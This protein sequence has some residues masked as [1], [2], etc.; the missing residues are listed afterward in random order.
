MAPTVSQPPTIAPTPYP[1]RLPTP[2]RPP[3]PTPGGDDDDGDAPVGTIVGVMLV[4]V[5]L[6]ICCGVNKSKIIENNFVNPRQAS[7]DFREVILE[8]QR[9]VVSVPAFACCGCIKNERPRLLALFFTTRI[10]AQWL[11]VHA[12][13]Q[14]ALGWLS[15]FC[16]IISFF[17][18]SNRINS[19]V[20]FMA[21]FA[22]ELLTHTW[23]GYLRY[24][25]GEN[26]AFKNMKYAL[27]VLKH[28]GHHVNENETLVDVMGFPFY[29]VMYL[30]SFATMIAT[31]CA[32]AICRAIAK[33][34]GKGQDKGPGDAEVTISAIIGVALGCVAYP[35]IF[36]LADTT[37][38][39]IAASFMHHCLS[40]YYEAKLF[41]KTPGEY[42]KAVLFKM[43]I[44]FVGFDDTDNAAEFADLERFFEETGAGADP[45]PEDM[46][47]RRET[48]EAQLD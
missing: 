13:M 14:L 45:D 25:G 9:L 39:K 11:P 15:L 2:A 5:A 42:L 28:G 29:A 10:K 7:D 3:Q 22:N 30:A 46:G 19:L 41:H 35:L 47:G 44:D 6:T 34:D 12:Y 26:Q 37:T 1:T 8:K 36:L 20:G 32:L 27:G 38:G 24:L 4:A 33:G 48:D 31:A 18:P 43:F 17:A 21:L 23:Y 16:T 40:E